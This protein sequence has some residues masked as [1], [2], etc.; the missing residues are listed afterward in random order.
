MFLIDTSVWIHWLRPRGDSA[1][2]DRVDALLQSGSAGWCAL[3]RLELWNGASG[4]QEQKV[5]R[6]L[7]ERLPELSIDPAVWDSACA[8]ARTARS[9]GLTVPATDILNF[10]CAR[11]HDVG[12]VHA[13][14][15]FDRLNALP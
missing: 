15:D 14:A 10:A 12:L 8:L 5:L 1:I 11:H 3:V 2:A 6:G 4:T 13:D 9:T 7:G